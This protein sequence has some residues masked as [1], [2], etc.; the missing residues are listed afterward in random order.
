MFEQND[1][2]TYHFEV[3]SHEYGALFKNIYSVVFAL[4]WISG[5]LN[6]L[7]CVAINEHDMPKNQK[8]HDTVPDILAHTLLSQYHPDKGLFFPH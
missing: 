4:S 3:W 6:E 5:C 2:T 7:V 8:Q 1:K